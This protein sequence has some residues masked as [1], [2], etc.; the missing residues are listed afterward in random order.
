LRD[1]GRGIVNDEGEGEEEEDDDD[2]PEEVRE[3][4]H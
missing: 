4:L 2:R 3:C 1:R